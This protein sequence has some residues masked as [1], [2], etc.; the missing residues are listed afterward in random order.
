RAGACGGSSRE[1]H[2]R[3]FPAPWR[4]HQ[5][6]IARPD[7]P[8]PRIRTERSCKYFIAASAG[9]PQGG[10]PPRGAANE[11]ERGGSSQLQARQADQA[12]QNADDPEGQ[13]EL[14]FLPCAML[15]MV[16]QLAH[17]VDEAVLVVAVLSH[18]GD[19]R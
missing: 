7:S 17:G 4:S 10:Q 12:Q 13:D 5:R 2:T 11:C 8:R 16:V 6:A 19:A 3:I 15:E 18:S 9:P 1:C 14:G